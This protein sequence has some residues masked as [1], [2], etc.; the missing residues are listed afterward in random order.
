MGKTLAEA[1]SPRDT[2]CNV[3]ALR[4]GG[5]LIM[6]PTPDVRLRAGAELLLICTTEGEGSFV[7][8]YGGGSGSNGIL[9]V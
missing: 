3:I 8:R 1:A 6:N 7:K 4:S 5:A 2:Q 9:R